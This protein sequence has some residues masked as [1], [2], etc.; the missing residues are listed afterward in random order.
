MVRKTQT[1]DETARTLNDWMQ[2]TGTNGRQLLALLAQAGRPLTA[3]TLSSILS[4]SRRCGL[5]TAQKLHEITG[6]P[7]ESIVEW[8]PRARFRVRLERVRE[9]RTNRASTTESRA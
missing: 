2:R 4:R 5:R 7:V 3:G 9:T 6:V 1:S 8:P